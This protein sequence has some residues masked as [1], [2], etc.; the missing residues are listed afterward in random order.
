M[1]R[2]L[3]KDDRI[4]LETIRQHGWRG[5]FHIPMS[6]WL[7][8]LSSVSQQYVNELLDI[9]ANELKTIVRLPGDCYKLTLCGVWRVHGVVQFLRSMLLDVPRGRVVLCL[10]EVMVM[11][12][13]AYAGEK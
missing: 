8:A 2:I 12:A 4:V 11:I 1:K 13:F 10:L 5:N 6:E 7:R 3:T 9:H